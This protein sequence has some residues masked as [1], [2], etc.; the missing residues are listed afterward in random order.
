MVE[1]GIGVAETSSHVFIGSTYRL[2]VVMLSRPP[3]NGLD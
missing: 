1:H 3:V 2:V